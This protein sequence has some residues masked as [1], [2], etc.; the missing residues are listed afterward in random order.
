VGYDEFLAGHVALNIGQYVHLIKQDEVFAAKAKCLHGF[1]LIDGFR[2]AGNEER[3]E[4][5]GLPG[6]R[7]MVPQVSA[8]PTHIDFEQA[9]N[10]GLVVG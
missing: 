2:H 5:E 3:R 7:S 10:H 4:R 1:V 6:F 9:M 8:S